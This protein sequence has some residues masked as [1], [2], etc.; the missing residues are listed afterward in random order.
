MPRKR[1]K[2]PAVDNERRGEVSPPKAELAP[3]TLL[4]RLGERARPLRRVIVA[5][6]GVGA[7]LGGFAGYWSAYRTASE[8]I[9]PTLISTVGT[10]DAGPL[11]VVV[12]PFRNFTG[13]PSQAYL[14]EGIT[15]ALTADVARIRDV[16]TI[17]TA[18]AFAYKDKALTAQQVGREL[19]VRFLLTGGVQRNADQL[20]VSAQLA[21]TSSGAQ[22]WAETFD[23]NQSNFLA[24]QE[25]VTTRI[26]YSIG[27]ETLR[28]AAR[29]SESR[30]NNPKTLDLTLR[31]RAIRL[32]KAPSPQSY[33][34]AISLYRRAVAL[35]P[36]DL[37]AT[38][39]L[40]TTLALSADNGLTASEA[41]KESYLK[42]ASALLQAVR[43]RAPEDANI[44]LVTGILASSR[45]DFEGARR[46]NEVA[47]KLEPKSPA[48]FSNLADD[49]LNAGQPEQAIGLLEQAVRLYP[50]SP[51]F[52]VLMNMGTAQLM[53]GQDNAAVEWLLKAR[54]G[55][56]ELPVASVYLAAAYARLGQMEHAR[57]ATAEALRLSPGLRAT[58][59]A[60]PRPGYPIAYHNFWEYKLLPALQLAGLPR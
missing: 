10:G 43:S 44:F 36:S 42:E 13:D 40:A 48:R 8:T 15:A 35:D 19:G 2:S 39:G 22:L 34:E 31:A 9:Q 12:L 46:A 60:R 47:L 26:A 18:T 37:E 28:A 23:G 6:A 45:G 24:L 53:A 32:T 50:R 16:F 51:N 7:I 11:S 58:E 5:V 17:S 49:Y 29:T 38:I 25:S 59:F 55:S 14:A 54:D 52:S 27:Q 56:P 20:I 1:L 30:T 33:R 21:D 4:A 41:E 57:A 3:Q